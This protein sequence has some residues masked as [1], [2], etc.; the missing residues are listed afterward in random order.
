MTKIEICN[1]ALLKIGADTIASLDINQNDQE[2]VVQSAKLCNILFTQALEEVL[3]TYRW[4]SALKRDKLSRLAETPAFKWKYK[5]Q[6][7][8][9]CVRVVNVYDDIEA[10]DDRTE[11]V[12]EGR[13]ILCDY[14]AVYLC[15]V[16]SVQD[17]NTLDAFLTQAV[18]QNLA[19][20]LSVPM[21]LDQVM[22][23]N[24]ISEYNN[25]IL[26]QAR[27]VDTLENKYWEM[28]ESDFLLSRF[29]QS[30]RF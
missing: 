20:K 22:Q 11:W 10:Y 23:N 4:N 18:I 8:N 30:P 13:T 7:P 9:E 1:H 12:V 25:V 24:L 28:E 27:S 3:R 29:N 15:Y 19:I 6:L 14:E 17:V 21:Q 26:P 16:A 5:Y 2:S